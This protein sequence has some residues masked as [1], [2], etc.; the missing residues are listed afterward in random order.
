MAELTTIARPYAEAVF[1]LAEQ[2]GTLAQWSQMLAVMARV[3]QH[4]DVL[5]F[6]GDP[7][8]ADAQRARVFLDLCGEGLTAEARNFVQ[9]LLDNGR[10]ALLPQI[11]ELFERQKNEREGVVD[12]EIN[13]AFALDDAQLQ[14]LVAELEGRFKRKVRPQ[15]TV[16]KELIG[17]VKVIIGDTVIDGSVRGKLADMS[18]ALLAV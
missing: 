18:A 4:P 11:H 10:L 5:G 8:V 17:G 1:E 3:A 15:V 7:K 16:D 9:L 2:S 12:A 6:I 13:T 14:G